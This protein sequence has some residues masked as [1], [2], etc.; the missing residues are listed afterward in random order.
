M[1]EYKTQMEAAKKGIITPEIRTVAQKEFKTPE[2]IMRSV[3][4]GE[5]CIPCNINHR[6]IS[7]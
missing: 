6:S 5:V 2:E 3:A 4:R 7:A 1:R